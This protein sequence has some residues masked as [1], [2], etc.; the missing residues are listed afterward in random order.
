NDELGHEA[1][2]AL[3]RMAA[4]AIST[5]EQYGA[6]I[7]RIGGDE[8]LAVLPDCDESFMQELMQKWESVYH[9]LGLTQNGIPCRIAVGMAFG[10]FSEGLD[11]VIRRADERMYIDKRRQKLHSTQTPF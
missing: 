8:F 10:D 1:G 3:I 7:Y 5:L 2:D 4:S 11:N 6:H 9:R